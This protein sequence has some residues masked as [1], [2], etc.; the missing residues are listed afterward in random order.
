V[1]GSRYETSLVI[2][3]S[4]AVACCRRLGDADPS[5]LYPD[6]DAGPLQ[7]ALRPIEVESRLASWDDPGVDRGSFSHVV[8]SS[9]WDSVDRPDEFL[10]WARSVS[11]A[12]TRCNP[13]DLASPSDE[14]SVVADVVVALVSARFEQPPVYSR[15]DL[16]RGPDGDPLVPEVELID[17]YLS[18]DM[19]PA[20]AARLARA[21]AGS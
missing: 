9:T 20:A 16:V 13:A 18:L 17:P 1:A 10:P 5:D 21:I 2:S 8:I 4:V 11:V 7:A 14:Q 6:A 3:P 15:V 12:S 19:E